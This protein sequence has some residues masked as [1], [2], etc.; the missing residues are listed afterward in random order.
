MDGPFSAIPLGSLYYSFTAISPSILG[1]LESQLGETKAY[2]FALKHLDN[3]RVVSL[4]PD[5]WKLVDQAAALTNEEFQKEYLPTWSISR[6][7]IE[8]N[9]TSGSNSAPD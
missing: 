5:E 2:Y 9:T 3:R 8:T 1:A 6:D 4:S 7:S